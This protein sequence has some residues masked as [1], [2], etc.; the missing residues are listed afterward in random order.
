MIWRAALSLALGFVPVHSKGAELPACV[1][2][3]GVPFGSHYRPIP[4]RKSELGH[5]LVVEGKVRTVAGCKPV[6][7]ARVEHW[8]AGRDGQ[9]KDALRAYQVTDRGGRFKF[10]TEWP[11][12]PPPHIHFRIDA[13]GHATLVSVWKMPLGGEPVKRLEL[14]F[15]LETR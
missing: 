8:Q 15:V 7:N 14:D 9:Y 6:Q 13:P 3:T 1:A 5:D 4:L 11:G 2:T 12:H 10:T